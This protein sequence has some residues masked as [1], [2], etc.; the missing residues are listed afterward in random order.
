MAVRVLS[1]V[2]DGYPGGGGDLL[3]LLALADWSDDGGKCYPSM[4]A[5]AR[6][7]RLSECQARRVV[8]RLIEGGFLKVTANATGGATSR[9]Y[10][11]ILDRLTP[12]ADATPS[13]DDRGRTGATPPLAPMR[14]DPSHSYATRTVN[15]PSTTVSRPSS[16]DE[17]CH[18]PPADDQ[19]SS[20]QKSDP[21]P[22]QQIVDAYHEHFPSGRRVSVLNAKRKQ[23]IAARW[24][25]VRKGEYRTAGQPQAPRDQ[26]Q[27]LHFFERYFAYCESLDWCTGREPMKDGGYFIATID[28]LMGSDFMAK[29][30][31]AAHDA[32]E[33]V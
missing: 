21:C 17:G 12:S 15:E 19:K 16:T 9:R 6:K 11:I 8:H 29:R 23:A 22:Y 7:V 26:A 24:G 31:D 30:S 33:A 4:A 3:A 27:A 20:R 1:R 13:A 2:W 10:Q 5:I 25:E 28:N 32:R 18:Q 14:G